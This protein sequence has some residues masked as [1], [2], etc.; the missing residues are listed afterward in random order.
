MKRFYHYEHRTTSLR[1]L[2]T[3]VVRRRPVSVRR[4]EF[5]L[6]DFNLC[7]ERGEAVALVGSNGSGKSTALRLMA[8]VYAPTEGRVWTRGRLGA[9]IELGVGF[10]PELT[11]AENVALYAAVMGLSRHESRERFPEITAFAE[12]GDFIDEPVKYYSSGMQARLAFA[13]AVCVRPDI[14][15]LDEVL[16]VGDRSFRE[17]CFDFLEGFRA[18]GGTMIIV[19]HD[20]DSVRRLCSRAVWMEHGRVRMI[21]PVER[22]MDAYGDVGSAGQ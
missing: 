6:V 13:V 7:V 16:A 5:S 21:G 2:F 9:V 22:V 17:R 14:L 20:A 12:I 3:R 11:G 15:L 18:R 19:T 8:G 4:A 10:H 1:E